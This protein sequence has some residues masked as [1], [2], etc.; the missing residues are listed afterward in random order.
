MADEELR[1]RDAIDQVIAGLRQDPASQIAW[2]EMYIFYRRQ[3]LGAL[4]IFGIHDDGDR[5]DLCSEVFFRFLA[6]SPWS[7]RWETLPDA[8]VIGAYLR[9]TALRLVLN[10]ARSRARADAA[11]D[12]AAP[13]E[14]FVP[15]EEL[16]DMLSILSAADREF[17][18]VYVES[19]F[20]LQRVAARESLT[21]S[22]AG[23]RLHRIRKKMQ[24]FR[25]AGER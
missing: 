5:D 7:E 12:R 1:S 22:G 24:R 13:G 9:T 2:R 14:A 18:E 4:Y 15:N 8:R 16:G 25:H 17:L 19:G 6:K 11:G 10:V 21:Y 3:V 23:T 20:S